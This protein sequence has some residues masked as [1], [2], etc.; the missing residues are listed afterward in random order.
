MREFYA[1]QREM[2]DDFICARSFADFLEKT[3]F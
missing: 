1:F 2:R 3:E